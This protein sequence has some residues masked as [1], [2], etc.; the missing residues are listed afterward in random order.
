[1]PASNRLAEVALGIASTPFAAGRSETDRLLTLVSPGSQVQSSEPHSHQ[2][3]LPIFECPASATV[4]TGAEFIVV[5]PGAGEN[6]IGRV[7]MQIAANRNRILTT[8]SSLPMFDWTS[9][10]VEQGEL[11]Q[12]VVSALAKAS[13]KIQSLGI[14]DRLV[15]IAEH[16]LGMR[17]TDI[18]EQVGQVLTNLLLPR[19][20]RSIGQYYQALAITRRGDLASSTA[21][22]ERLAISP[23]TPMRYRARALKAIG[24]NHLDL[25]NCDEALCFFLE[26]GHAASPKYGGDLLTAT[27]SQWMLAVI[28]SFNGDHKEALQDLERLSSAIRLLAIDQPFIYYSYANSLAVESGE[29]GYMEMARTASR[30]ALASPFACARPEWHETAKEIQQKARR[31]SSSVVAI[32]QHVAQTEHALKRRS[33]DE[34]SEPMIA[35]QRGT[36]R[37]TL[38]LFRGRSDRPQEPLYSPVEAKQSHL[39]LT[40]KRALL[41]DL[42]AG[43]PEEA[44][45]R[46][47]AL[48]R[49]LD[50]Q[51]SPARRPREINLE[52]KSILEQLMTL[53][54][55]GDFGPDDFAAVMSALRDCDD[56]L[57]R[58]TIIDRMI[59]Y[60]YYF[61]QDRMEGEDFWRKRVEARLTPETDPG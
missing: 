60:S 3:P 35:G 28:K 37:K 18:V 30:I 11:Y 9:Q 51:S 22:L 46:L 59:S 43:L 41:N 57:R 47:L 29:L 25:G 38:L 15:R 32:N 50:A 39:S 58:K 20:Y 23:T 12:H 4:A 13:R 19:G 21:I 10:V 52:E 24:G 26:A 14:G 8:V 27:L 45:D 5:L 44:L 6:H 7:K 49:E 55:N 17:Q 54:V 1:M 40:R 34:Q 33:T 2:A 53:W 31:A 61:T 36:Q 16:A 42:S 48:A 56:D